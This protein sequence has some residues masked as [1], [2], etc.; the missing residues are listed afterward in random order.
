MP[1]SAEF[2]RGL[3]AVLPDVI[4]RFGTPFHIYDAAGIRRTC[5]L[6]DAAFAGVD[7]REYFAVKALPNPT[8]LRLLAEHG[9]GFDTSSLAELT[10]AGWAGASGPEICFTTCNTSVAE[11]AAAIDA[12]ASVTIDDAAILT[13]LADR[14]AVP[15]SLVFRVN[16]GR[17]LAVANN[18]LF[19]DPESTKFG[20]RVDQLAAVCERA[21]GL[22]VRELGLH[23][24]MASNVLR[25]EP[26]LLTLDLL[27]GQARELEAAVGLPVTSLNL[28]GGIGIPYRPDERPFDLAALGAAVRDRLAD[29]DRVLGSAR[30]T[31]R[32]ECGRYITGPHGALVTRVVNRMDKWRTFVGVD[33]S[34]VS[35]M[36]PSLYSWAYHHITAPFAGGRPRELVDVIGSLPENGDRLGRD[37]LL[38]VL[39]TGDVL[40]VHDTG[41]HGHAMGFNYTGRPRPAELLLRP[42]GSVERIRRA[43]TERDLFASLDFEPCRLAPRAVWERSA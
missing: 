28:G 9:F 8:V 20:I 10:L 2:E 38:P 17:P 13:A 27:L 14:F 37:R 26:V 16:P 22:G 35:L 25:P 23:M 4:E 34:M 43:E 36:R 3:N 5:E 41:A 42:D 15:E 30:P 40:V 31:I 39:G 1:M 7:Y 33:A 6:F 19:G 29:W 32:F 21:R 18:H 12:G 24:M 11:L